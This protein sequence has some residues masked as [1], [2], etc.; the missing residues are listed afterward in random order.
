MS[1]TK[2]LISTDSHTIHTG[3][4]ETTRLIFYPLLDKYGD[5]Y[6]LHQIGLFNTN[7]VTPPRWPI[8]PTRVEKNP[9]GSNRFREQ[10]RYGQE[11]FPEVVSKLKPDIVFGY[12]D[13]WYVQHMAKNSNI[14][15]YALVLYLTYDGTPYPPNDQEWL[16][17]ADKFVTLSHFSKHVIKSCM[18]QLDESKVDVMYSPADVHRFCPPSEEER[19]SLRKNAFPGHIPQDAFVMGWI[20]RNQWRKQVWKPYEVLHYLNSG[21]Y[22]V[23]EDCGEITP[24]DWDPGAQ[25][26]LD[27]TG[28]TLA[29]P[30]GF[31]FDHCIHCKSSNIKRAEPLKDIFLWS[32]MAPEDR[33]WPMEVI[34]KQFNTR[35]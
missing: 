20:G 30:P 8:Y 2:I 14:K 6:E 19:A 13:P 3:L 15:D 31:E 10:D 12:G 21:G 28:R 4:A 35:S 34:H 5:Q 33:F 1:K 27:G 26:F 24:I 22:F 7:P 9:N 17:N 25:E 16:K 23:C 32:H 29:S 11:T 18:P